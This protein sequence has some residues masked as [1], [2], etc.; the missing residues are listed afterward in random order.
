MKSIHSAHGQQEDIQNG[1]IQACLQSITVPLFAHQS[2]CFA[3][4]FCT[5]FY[6][7]I[8]YKITNYFEHLCILADVLQ[9]QFAADYGMN[10]M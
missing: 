7:I 1:I 3:M 5:V 6:C 8:S 2:Q 4:L 10:F 9:Y